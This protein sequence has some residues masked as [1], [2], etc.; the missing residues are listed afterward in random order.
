MI[1][2]KVIG[3]IFVAISGVMLTVTL[4][5]RTLT[6]LRQTEGWEQLLGQIKTEVECFS[7]PISDILARTDTS[8]LR[9]CGYTGAD[10][11]RGLLELVENTAFADAEVSRIARRFAS[12]FGRCYKGEQVERC[13][14]FTSLMS[15]RRQSIAAEL[16]SKRKLNATLCI[17]TSLGLLIFFF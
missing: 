3:A 9:L 7:L 10:A 2:F 5:R 13:A 14:Y 8:L 11:P 1:Y 17:A 6:V 12:E 16:P 15:G 4:N